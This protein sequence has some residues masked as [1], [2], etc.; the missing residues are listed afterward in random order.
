MQCDCESE[1]CKHVPGACEKPPILK[2]AL[3]GFEENIC[4]DC[5]E[6]INPVDKIAGSYRVVTDFRPRS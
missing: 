3:F 1:S 6:A 2:V 5:D 4:A